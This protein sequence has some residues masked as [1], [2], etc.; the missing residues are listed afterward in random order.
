MTRE[1][2]RRR[3]PALGRAALRQGAP[4]APRLAA[5]ASLP[6]HLGHRVVPV[7]LPARLGWSRQPAPHARVAPV[8]PR[9]HRAHRARRRLAATRLFLAPPLPN[10]WGF[11]APSRPERGPRPFH[12]HARNPHR[13]PHAAKTGCHNGLSAP[14]LAAGAPRRA[15]LLRWRFAAEARRV[16]PLASPTAN[17]YGLERAL[18]RARRMAAVRRGR[19]SGCGSRLS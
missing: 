11:V 10:L 17:F 18:A 2:Q 1:V 3:L 15:P 6:R 19:A 14:A 7:G 8:R 4:P 12:R 5:G 9:V 13:A 16:W